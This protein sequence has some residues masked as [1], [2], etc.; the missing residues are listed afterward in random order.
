MRD[1]GGSEAAI[2]SDLFFIKGHDYREKQGFCL[3]PLSIW[4]E[5][6]SKNLVI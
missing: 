4:K 3:A 2:S 1:C 6:P 5:G